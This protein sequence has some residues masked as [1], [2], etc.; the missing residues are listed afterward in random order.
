MKILSFLALFLL[1]LFGGLSASDQ[2]AERFG[3]PDD[4]AQ[5]KKQIARLEE[6]IESLEKRLDCIARPRIIP[7]KR[8]DAFEE[9]P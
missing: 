2:R 1:L 6:R 3:L 9:I 7:V 4:L 8:D 5:L